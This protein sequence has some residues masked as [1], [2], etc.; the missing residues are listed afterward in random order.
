MWAW[1]RRSFIAGFFVTVP[2]VVSVVAIV[3]VFRFLDRV[4][5]AVGQRMFGEVWPGLGIVV[6]ALVILMVGALTANVL[7]RRV[8]SRSE[9]LL[10]QVPLFKTVYAPVKQLLTA[11]S[12]DNEG[13]FKRMVLIEDHAKG[14]V[15]GFLTKEF[16]VDRGSG[17]EKLLAVYVPTNHLYLGDIVICH[18]DRVSYPDLSVQDGI[19]VFLSGGTGL[20]DKM[21]ATAQDK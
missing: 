4:T 5:S 17:P 7:V 16:V 1:L 11:F 8:L 10:L 12:P 2:L 20:P 14:A 18:P 3:W 13:G 21:H 9:H 19:R 6:T 15:L